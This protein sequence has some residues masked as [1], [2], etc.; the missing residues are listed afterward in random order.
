MKFKKLLNI[1]VVL[2]LIEEEMSSDKY[3]NAGGLFVEKGAINDEYTH[4]YY[5]R[6]LDVCENRYG[7]NSGDV[8]YLRRVYA[9][10]MYKDDEGGPY[11]ITTFT[12]I[13]AKIHDFDIEKVFKVEKKKVGEKNGRSK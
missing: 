8:V 6:V 1:Q 12:N 4:S 10:E 3:V 9:R 11:M 13:V 5:A 7:I 2:R